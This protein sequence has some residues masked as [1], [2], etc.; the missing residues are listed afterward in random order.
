[1]VCEQLGAKSIEHNENATDAKLHPWG[2]CFF[3]LSSRV[4]TSRCHRSWRR[5][6]S[7]YW[8]WGQAQWRDPPHP[9]PSLNGCSPGLRPDGL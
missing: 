1:M 3:V 7:H 2:I 8:R 6:L 5:S 9:H 4:V